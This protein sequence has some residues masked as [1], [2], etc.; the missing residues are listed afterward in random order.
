MS[1]GLDALKNLLS[2]YDYLNDSYEEEFGE[3]C[4]YVLDENSEKVLREIVKTDN[5]NKEG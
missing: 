4:P 3:E 1:K 2:A 5:E